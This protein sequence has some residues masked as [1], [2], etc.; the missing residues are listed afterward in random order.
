MIVDKIK[1][2]TRVSLLEEEFDEILFKIDVNIDSRI[3]LLESRLELE[4]LR[5]DRITYRQFQEFEIRENIRKRLETLESKVSKRS[6]MKRITGRC[7]LFFQN[8]RQRLL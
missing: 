8:I 3:K 5:N 6:L 2:K 4:Q 1:T 7:S